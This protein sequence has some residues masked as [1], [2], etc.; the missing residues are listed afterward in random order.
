MDL[1][2]LDSSQLSGWTLVFH[3]DLLARYPLGKKIA[4]H[5][6]FS[7]Q[8]NEALHLSGQEEA[9]LDSLIQS[10]KV[11]Y[12]R[13]IDDFSQDV[14]V[15]QIEVLL[16]YAN[17]FYNRQFITRCTPENNRDGGS[18]LSRFEAFLIDY[19]AQ[20]GDQPLPTVQY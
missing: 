3:P 14:L 8:T 11:E 10:I 17:R 18:L 15:S 19:F 7:Y 13:P 16:N 2:E 1:L 5:G 9:I 4:G 20:I 6:F 12:D